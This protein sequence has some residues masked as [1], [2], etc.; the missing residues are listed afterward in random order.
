MRPRSIE[1]SR[2]EDLFRSKLCNIINLRHPLA[3]LSQLIDWKHLEG[4][5]A[6]TSNR[7]RADILSFM[8][9]HCTVIPMTD[10]R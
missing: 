4:H 3:R 10:I 9:K 7:A 1:G 6:P 5:F 2:S 8:Q